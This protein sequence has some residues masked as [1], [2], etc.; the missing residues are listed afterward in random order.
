MKSVSL[1]GLCR[2]C[3]GSWI[4]T[5]AST[6]P[7]CW[8]ASASGLAGLNSG[9]VSIRPSRL[10]SAST[11]PPDDLKPKPD[12]LVGLLDGFGQDFVDQDFAALN[13]EVCV[14]VMALQPR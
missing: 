9:S 6:R 8:P 10:L 12:T 14:V 7:G 1:G 4:G 5:V 11:W 3:A 2:A 13:A